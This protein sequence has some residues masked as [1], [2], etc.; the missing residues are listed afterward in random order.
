MKSEKMP[1]KFVKS[2]KSPKVWWLSYLLWKY[3]CIAYCRLST[4]E[5]AY[6]LKH[7]KRLCFPTGNFDAYL[8]HPELK[9]AYENGHL[10]AINY[11]LCYEK[12]Y[13]FIEYVDFFYKLKQQYDREGN[14]AYRFMTKRMMNSLYGKFGQLVDKLYFEDT[15]D[16]PEYSQERVFDPENG[17]TYIQ[18]ILGIK[19]KVYEEKVSEYPEALVAI[20]AHI[21][22][23][24]RMLLWSLIKKAGRENVFYCDTDSIFTN[25]AGY[26]RLQKDIHPDRLGALSIDKKSDHVEIFG[27]KDYVFGDDVVIKGVKKGSEQD[28]KGR[29]MTL[30]FPGFKGALKRG[31]KSNYVI[32]KVNKTLS[33]EYKK[34]IKQEDGTVDPYMIKEF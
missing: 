30:Q 24:S 14:K 31:L 23:A 10:K 8:A 28:A 25:S 13:L 6:P 3:N 15:V 4:D 20:P 11:L 32:K 16:K 9:Y 5:P 34:G 18:R 2:Y 12:D 33:R 7:Q 29:Y 26:M 1:Y 17:K 22:S 21:T 27:A 19:R